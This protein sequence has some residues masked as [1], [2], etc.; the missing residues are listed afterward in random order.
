MSQPRVRTPKLAASLPKLPGLGP[1]SGACP[2]GLSWL[3]VVLG[4][5]EVHAREDRW[6]DQHKDNGGAKG[7]SGGGGRAR[8]PQCT[9]DTSIC[10][11]PNPYTRSSGL[12]LPTPQDLRWGLALVWGR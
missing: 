6:W 3:L 1:N 10:L 11:N 5:T 8:G 9:L 4:L 12:P 7:D 2:G